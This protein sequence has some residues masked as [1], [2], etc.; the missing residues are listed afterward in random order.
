[1]GR[2]RLWRRLAEDLQTENLSVSKVPLIELYGG[3]RVLIENHAGVQEY[4]D[5]FICVRVKCGQVCISG[6]NLRLALMSQERLVICGCIDS[7]HRKE[8]NR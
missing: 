2:H 8:G 4:T 6:R 7:V 1:M 5:D 3:R